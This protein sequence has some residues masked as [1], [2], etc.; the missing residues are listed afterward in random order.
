MN[1]DLV[2]SQSLNLFK[3][4]VRRLRDWEILLVIPLL[5]ACSPAYADPATI[6]ASV[7]PPTIFAKMSE[8]SALDD[9]ASQ[10]AAAINV[11]PKTVR[12]RI[13][14][15]NCTVCRFEST[16]QLS[17]AEGL[18][19]EEAT[20]LVEDQDKVSFFVPRF[21]CTFLFEENKYSPQSCQLSPV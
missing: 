12:V 2:V 8:A 17:K 11:D 21:S 14:P 3:F 15:G 9:G 10:F 20:K 1:P 6:A 19:I 5:V 7:D 13:Q 16:P 4:V 18:N